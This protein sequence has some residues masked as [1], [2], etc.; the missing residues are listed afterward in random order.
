MAAEYDDRD[1]AGTCQ[2]ER[3]GSRL[4]AA[5]GNPGVVHDE[6]AGASHRP[7]N[8]QPVGIYAPDVDNFRR[9]AQPD[10]RQVH[11]RPH[12]ADKRMRTRPALA[13]WHH[14]DG[15]RPGVHAG[16]PPQRVALVAQ[17]RG[18][19]LAQPRSRLG[20]ARRTLRLIPAQVLSK[21]L[22]A[23]REPN[24]RD[25]IRKQPASLAKRHFTLIT[26]GESSPNRPPAGAAEHTQM[27]GPPT[28]IPCTHQK[29]D[30]RPVADAGFQAADV[31]GPL[32]V[33][34][35]SDLDGYME[36]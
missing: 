13:A 1:T 26:P 22:A 36:R 10:Q 31:L 3:G 28:D 34:R 18:K 23:H 32:D 29:V 30:N 16:L 24:G 4:R 11:A 25:S 33:V 17:E 12:D 5:T 15:R 27:L 6:D 20:R 9:D 8:T 14:S 19:H 21:R 7:G 2:L 35:P